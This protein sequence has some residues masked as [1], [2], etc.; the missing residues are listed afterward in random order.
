MSKDYRLKHLIQDLWRS[1]RLYTRT[2]RGNKRLGMYHN[3]AKKDIPELARQIYYHIYHPSDFNAFIVTFPKPR[4]IFCGCARDR[5]VQTWLI[6]KLG[7]F[8]EDRHISLGNVCHS[9]RKGFGM[10]TGI[11]KVTDDIELLSNAYKKE[12]WVFKGDLSNFYV[13]I[14]KTRL[15]DCIQYLIEN[16]YEGED[17]IYLSEVAREIILFRP[18]LHCTR[19][20]PVHMWSR[21]KPG[22]SLFENAPNRGIASGEPWS[23]IFSNYFLS[24][25]DEYIINQMGDS[26]F[27]FTR[28]VDDFIIVCPD[29]NKLKRV[30]SNLRKW[31]SDKLH[32]EVHKQKIYFQPVSHGVKFLG[33]WIKPFRLYLANRTIGRMRC[34]IFGFDRMMREKKNL[35]PCE[36]DHIA[37]SINSYLGFLN[38][39]S[40]YKIRREIMSNLPKTFSKYFN[41]SPNYGKLNIKQKY[42]YG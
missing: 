5:V 40:E 23:Q 34:K 31:M 33:T 4:E 1:Y 42:R 7:K 16:N 10:E 19:N 24:Y 9:N 25:M 3:S 27:G 30:V 20:N 37:N 6:S 35:G 8:I 15:N 22:R 36:I 17:K 41:V 14:D 38:A 39:R 13:S 12:C 18:E 21:L 26:E 29:K 2:H 32:L 11:K 28:F